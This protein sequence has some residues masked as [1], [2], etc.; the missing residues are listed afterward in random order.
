MGVSGEGW[1]RAWG[2]RDFLLSVTGALQG[3]PPL[4]V[5]A[6]CLDLAKPPFSVRLGR[7]L[8]SR[9]SMSVRALTFEQK[10][11]HRACSA[12][13]SPFDGIGSP[14]GSVA[15]LTL[16]A[17]ALPETKALRPPRW[18]PPCLERLAGTTPELPGRGRSIPFRG[19]PGL[20][21]PL[22]RRSTSLFSSTT[23]PPEAAFVAGDEVRLGPDGRK[24][25]F[26]LRPGVLWSGRP[27][28]LV[29]R[30]QVHLRSHAAAARVGPG[31]RSGRSQPRSRPSTPAPSSSR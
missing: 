24:L 3:C 4:A 12:G 10:R 2:G 27:A 28:V 17:T 6:H 8:Q 19:E 29:G 30:R 21:G 31:G 23:G 9:G 26:A 22:R 1:V 5:D 7:R 20:S 13:S 11:Y 18:R 16:S 25:R 14:R 15:T